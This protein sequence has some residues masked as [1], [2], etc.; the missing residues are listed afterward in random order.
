MVEYVFGEKDRLRAKEILYMIH[1]KAKDTRDIEGALLEPSRRDGIGVIQH[2]P[3]KD[4]FE[5]VSIFGK[6]KRRL[7]KND[8]LV[9]LYVLYV[10]PEIVVA[11]TI[12]PL[13][14]NRKLS[15]N[16][17]LL[18]RIVLSASEEVIATQVVTFMKTYFRNLNAKRF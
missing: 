12:Y 2:I 11:T 10:E 3:S 8:D 18:S 16:E 7:L 4:D 14:F 13:A 15:K 17:V 1:E 9:H 6:G 5:Y